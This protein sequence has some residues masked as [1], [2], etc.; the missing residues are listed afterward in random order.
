MRTA[1]GDISPENKYNEI[2][3]VAQTKIL[4]EFRTYFNDASD[5]LKMLF[6]LENKNKKGELVI[7]FS[8]S[9]IGNTKGARAALEDIIDVAR[10]KMGYHYY[11]V[12]TIYHKAMQDVLSSMR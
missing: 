10:S 4:E 11:Q 3:Q 12:E 5:I 1:Y 6:D 7:K 2:L 9:F 8:P